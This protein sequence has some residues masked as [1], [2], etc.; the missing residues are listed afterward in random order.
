M[1]MHK[2]RAISHYGY[3]GNALGAFGASAFDL[4]TGGPGF[5]GADTFNN[6]TGQSRWA[7]SADV[8]SIGY[9]PLSA[10]VLNQASKSWIALDSSINPA[11]AEWKDS[12]L[13]EMKALI[14]SADA[15]AA[16][17]SI[18][19]DYNRSTTAALI[20]A[21]KQLQTIIRQIAVRK[22][23]AMPPD[24]AGGVN[25]FSTPAPNNPGAVN[26]NPSGVPGDMTSGSAAATAEGGT[27]PLVYVGVAVGGL[28]L[29]GGLY[30]IIRRRSSGKKLSGYR[31]KRRRR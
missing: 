27:S 26:R 20:N 5:Q 28:A 8:A 10:A 9:T 29:L 7:I 25:D 23:T 21:F 18:T 16:N 13:A 22:V 14:A 19:G 1:S 15:L 12:K 17:H 30:V 3:F 31:R 2:S 24:S 6:W 4:F 11:D